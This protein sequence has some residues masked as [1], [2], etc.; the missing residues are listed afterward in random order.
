MEALNEIQA[1]VGG[2]LTVSPRGLAVLTVNNGE[3]IFNVYQ[4]P[5]GVQ[6]LMPN[7]ERKPFKSAKL[8]SDWMKVIGAKE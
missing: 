7:G 8:C 6:I 5:N 4:K 1:A 3:K 2:R